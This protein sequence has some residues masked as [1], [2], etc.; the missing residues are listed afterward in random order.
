MTL[1][2][3]YRDALKN[4]F[5]DLSL[6]KS[7]LDIAKKLVINSSVQFK[8]SLQNLDSHLGT[9]TFNTD[10]EY[11]EKRIEYIE[12][13]I[14]Q[15]INNFILSLTAEKIPFVSKKLDDIREDLYENLNNE[16]ILYKES[17]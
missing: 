11:H 16:T 8:D 13:C 14:N 6:N 10:E 7:S 15:G 2:E 17:S 9:F 4:Y 5:D 1:V 3:N 12:A